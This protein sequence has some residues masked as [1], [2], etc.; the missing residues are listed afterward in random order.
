MSSGLAALAF[1]GFIVWLF[2][3]DRQQRPAISYAL[4]LPVIWA[5]IVGSRPVS[6]WFGIE[7]QLD[8][9]ESSI[10]GSAF[11]RNLFLFLIMA[12]ACVLWSRK[13]DWRRIV[14]NNKWM[15]AF[16]VYIA[17]SALWSDYPFVS[18]KRWVKIFG[19]VV[20]VL[21]ILTDKNP[22]QAV[23]AVLLRCGYLLIPLS[24][25]FIKYY[26]HIGRGYARYTMEPIC[27]GVTLGKNEFGVMV[28]LCG[29]FLFWELVQVYESKAECCAKLLFR[30][31]HSCS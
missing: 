15:C 21:V 27:M 13:I 14:T 17:I 4:W 5:A 3:M 16:F 24:V 1:G 31:M 20:M 11:D 19:N 7:V 29:L 25:L 9:S 28:A 30:I 12:G 18:L 10:E 6:F 26:P 22:V 23:R 8:A 2:V